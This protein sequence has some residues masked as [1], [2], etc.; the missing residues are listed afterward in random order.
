MGE[1]RYFI[2]Y[3]H[4]VSQHW[5]NV[6]SERGVLRFAASQH[7]CNEK[8]GFECRKIEQ[9]LKVEVISRHEVRPSFGLYPIKD[10]K[11]IVPDLLGIS[12]TLREK[13]TVCLRCGHTHH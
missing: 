7:R 5:A 12:V 13:D 1:E 8:D 2:Y 9:V 3:K 6:E 4:G 10:E 11:N